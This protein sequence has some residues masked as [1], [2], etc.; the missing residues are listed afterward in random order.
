[1]KVIVVN[2]HLDDAVGGSEIQCDLIARELLARGHRVVYVAAD[3]N[4]PYEQ[5]PYRIVPV[6]MR[7]QDIA[8]VCLAERPD[9]VYWRLNKHFLR[10]MA[11]TLDAN[12][13]PLVVAVS[14]WHD[15]LAWR[16]KASPQETA[17]GMFKRL[18]LER[19]NFS[20]YRWVSGV[21]CQTREQLAAA[22]KLR[23]VVIPNSARMR[24][25]L[26]FSWP[27]PYVAWVANLKASKRPELCVELARHLLPHGVDL[28]MV[29]RLVDPAYRWLEDYV[30]KSQ[31]LHYIGARSVEEVS[32]VLATALALVHTCMPEGFP[33]IFIQS[34][35]QGTPTVSIE[36][37]PGGIIKTHALGYVS[38]ADERR[39][40]QDVLRL[41]KDPALARKAGERGRRYVMEH[42]DAKTNVAKLE[43]FLREVVGASGIQTSQ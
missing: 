1:M 15:L 3:G 11:K 20:G 43:T 17:L 8:N 24:R 22:P 40:H 36:Y 5:H 2:R 32:G 6:A 41:V 10:C 28:V 26:P 30:E 29:G 21:V 42:C 38:Q 12:H 13:V 34:W 39:F 25:S 9:V 4:G 7:G 14:H 19:W 16:I 31:N 23:A 33:N 37:D 18:L 27:R 35:Q